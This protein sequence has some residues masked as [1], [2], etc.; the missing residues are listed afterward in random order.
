MSRNMDTRLPAGE[1]IRGLSTTADKIRA[2]ANANYDRKE[3]SKF[4]G[5]RYQHVCHAML[6]SCLTGGLRHEVEAE[7]EPIEVDAA[8]GPREDTASTVLTDAGFEYMGEWTQDPESLLRL[9]ARA[10]SLPGV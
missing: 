10:P 6:S 1:V 9:D 2:L 7:R 3:I 8:P 4:L 5:I